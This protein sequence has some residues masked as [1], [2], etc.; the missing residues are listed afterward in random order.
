MTRDTRSASSFVSSSWNITFDQDVQFDR[1]V[2]IVADGDT[3][4]LAVDGNIVVTGV[5]VSDQRGLNLQPTSPLA[6]ATGTHSFKVTPLGSRKWNYRAT[7]SLIGS[8]HVT[9]WGGWAEAA[10]G[11]PAGLIDRTRGHRANRH[12]GPRLLKGRTWQR[13]STR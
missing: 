7:S 13:F 5:V 9:A 8:S 2:C 11:F 3:Y 12:L 1:F 10:T 4:Q 6:L